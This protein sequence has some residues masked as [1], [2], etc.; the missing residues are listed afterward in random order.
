MYKLNV[1]DGLRRGRLTRLR[2]SYRSVAAVAR[3]HSDSKE[4]S[5]HFSTRISASAPTM[6]HLRCSIDESRERRLCIFCTSE[7]I[8]YPSG[9]ARLWLKQ[10]VMIAKLSCGWSSY[11]QPMTSE[12]PRRPGRHSEFGTN[13]ILIARTSRCTSSATGFTETRFSNCRQ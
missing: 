9:K 1:C 11:D 5:H 2:I 6:I 7:C 8:F 3:T 4:A 13:L 10:G 12:R